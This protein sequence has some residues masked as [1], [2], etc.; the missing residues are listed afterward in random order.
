MPGAKPKQPAGGGFRMPGRRLSFAER[1]EISVGVAR[2]ESLRGGAR[3]G[4]RGRVAGGAAAHPGGSDTA[5]AVRGA[6]HVY[7]AET[8]LTITAAG[9]GAA[10][11]WDALAERW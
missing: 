8:F 4:R 10:A 2:G 1:E 9:C 3:R 11:R 7:P 6:R 5:A